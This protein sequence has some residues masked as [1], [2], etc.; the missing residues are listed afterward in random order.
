[1]R[2]KPPLTD[3]DLVALQHRSQ[4]PIRVVGLWGEILAFCAYEQPMERHLFYEIGFCNALR[5]EITEGVEL[6][7]KRLFG[8]NMSIWK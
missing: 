1:M 6:V 3:D 4:P 8:E 5:N 2:R 7:L